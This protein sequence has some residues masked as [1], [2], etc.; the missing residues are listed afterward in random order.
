VSTLG[1]IGV[2]WPSTNS[3][4]SKSICT[5]W[6]NLEKFM[7]AKFDKNV[8][9]AGFN[10]IHSGT[11]FV[12]LLQKVWN[13]HANL[14]KVKTNF[15]NLNCKLVKFEYKCVKIAL[16]FVKYLKTS[17]AWQYFAEIRVKFQTNAWS[18]KTPG[19]IITCACNRVYVLFIFCFSF[20]F[21]MCCVLC[22]VTFHGFRPSVLR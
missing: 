22:P 2:R 9:F 14:W 17:P 4:N 10:R 13:W 8:K 16:K 3:W 6:G 21:W 18:W 1:K 11:K 20:F 19:N 12:K 5:T 15:Y 7:F